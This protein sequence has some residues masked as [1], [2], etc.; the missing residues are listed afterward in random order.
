MTP[1]PFQAD[2]F[3]DLLGR[4]ATGVT[5]LTTRDADGRD[6]GMTVSA[7]TAVSLDPPLVLACIGHDASIADAV[8]AASH[9]GLSVLA[10]DQEALSLHFADPNTDRFDGVPCSRGVIGVALL[11]GAIAHLECRI[12][13]RHDDGD[14]TIVVGEVLAG[15]ARDGEPLVHFRGGYGHMAS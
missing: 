15:S 1:V 5:V 8:A 6:R 4:F 2:A 10:A 3:R 7:L 9:F 11:D 13:A 12:H 14:H